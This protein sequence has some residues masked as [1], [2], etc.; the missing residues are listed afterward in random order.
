MFTRRTRP[1]AR[2]TNPVYI[3]F[4]SRL[5]LLILC[6]ICKF[7]IRDVESDFVEKIGQQS[8]RTVSSSPYGKISNET[9]GSMINPGNTTR[10]SPRKPTWLQEDKKRHE[11]TTKEEGSALCVL[12]AQA[13]SLRDPPA[14]PAGIP[15]KGA[16]RTS[17]CKYRRLMLPSH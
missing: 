3:N 17:T 2:N 1:N 12:T 14:A 9:K 7:M 15:W 6:T 11:G 16:S 13:L 8:T 5:F 4:N 10:L